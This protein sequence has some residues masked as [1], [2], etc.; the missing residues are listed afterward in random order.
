MKPCLVLIHEH[1]PGCPLTC[2]GWVD[3]L[4][5][6]LAPGSGRSS[7]VHHGVSGLQQPELVVYLQELEGAPAA[8]V[9]L[10]RGFDIRVFKLPGHPA[11][12]GRTSS[13]LLLHETQTRV[14]TSPLQPH[15]PHCCDWERSCAPQRPSAPACSYHSPIG[16]E[17]RCVCYLWSHR[18]TIRWQHQ[19]LHVC[20]NIVIKSPAW[21]FIFGSIVPKEMKDQNVHDV[22]L[23]FAFL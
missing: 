10:V 5:D 12:L 4:D 20:F 11:L 19:F 1:L 22:Y 2:P 7:A 8:E 3:P 16:R 18:A 17:E 6:H 14:E 23:L 9:Q 21:L 15:A 13:F